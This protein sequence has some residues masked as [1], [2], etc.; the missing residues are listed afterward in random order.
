MSEERFKSVEW[1]YPTSTNAKRFGF[2]DTG[3]WTV[4][5]T[6]GIR[7]PKATA[8]FKT[9][10]EAMAHAETMS[11]KWSNLFLSNHPSFKNLSRLLS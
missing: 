4:Q 2:H 11:E 1:S 5:L 9:R 7:P 8:G 10:E 3:C 6:K